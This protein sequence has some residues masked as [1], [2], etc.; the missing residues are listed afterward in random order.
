MAGKKA[1]AVN[2]TP[3]RLT[4]TVDACT[5]ESGADVHLFFCGLYGPFLALTERNGN[6]AR[7]WPVAEPAER[8]PVARGALAQSADQGRA[9]L[10][11]VDSRTGPG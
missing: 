7:R 1:Q 9:S 2:G 8:W 11:Y 6:P 3:G 10:G 5:Q 4:A